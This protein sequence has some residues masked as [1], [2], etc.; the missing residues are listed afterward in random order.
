MKDE[1]RKKEREEKNE[2]L[3]RQIDKNDKEFKHMEK[4]NSKNVN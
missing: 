4:T 2:R 3:K 1:Y